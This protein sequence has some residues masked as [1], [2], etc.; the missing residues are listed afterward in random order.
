MQSAATTTQTKQDPSNS[1][2]CVLIPDDLGIISII[3]YYNFTQTLTGHKRS[4]NS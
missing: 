4:G 3:Q 1:N 2:D